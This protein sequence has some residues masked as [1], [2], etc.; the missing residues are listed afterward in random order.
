[1]GFLDQETV[2]G[3][4]EIGGE[5]RLFSKVFTLNSDKQYKKDANKSL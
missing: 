1:M 3:D 5:N 4:K 2:S